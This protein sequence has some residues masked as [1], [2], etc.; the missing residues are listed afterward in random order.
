MDDQNELQVNGTKNIWS[1]LGGLLVGGLTGAVT[2]LLLAPQ[3][4]KRTRVKIQQKSIEL[5]DQTTDAIDDALAQTR[6]KAQQIKSSVRHQAVAIQQHGQEVL[7]EQKAR[8]STLVESGKT[9]VQG[10]LS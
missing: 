8:L 6:H 3:S 1:F 5:R 4:G 2:M 7:D 10:V 9:A